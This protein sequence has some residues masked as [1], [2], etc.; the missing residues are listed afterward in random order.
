MIIDIS[1]LIHPAMPVWPGDAPVTFT[2]TASIGP[3]SPV[4]VSQIGLSVHTGAHV[5]AP[6]HF[7]PAGQGIDEVALATFIGPCRVIHV[8]GAHGAVTPDQIATHLVD[9]PPRVLLRTC[10]NAARDAWNYDFCAVAPATVD[11]LATAGVQLIGLDT[12]SLDPADSEH[13]DAHLAVCRHRMLILEGLVLDTVAEGDYELIALP[14]KL[15]GLDGSP[16]R[17]ILRKSD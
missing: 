15:A 5:D 13:L 10:A 14:L 11:L 8:I 16:V 9:C 2:R 1:P 6:F 4:N 17:A 7:D 12:P 3:D